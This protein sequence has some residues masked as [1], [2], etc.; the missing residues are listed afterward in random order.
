MTNLTTKG[1]L[2]KTDKMTEGEYGKLEHCW[3]LSPTDIDEQLELKL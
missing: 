3:S 2:I 1:L